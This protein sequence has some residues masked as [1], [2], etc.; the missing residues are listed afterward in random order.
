MKF[1]ICWP[2]WS[3]VTRSD[4]TRAV[5][6][7]ASSLLNSWLHWMTNTS[8]KP[9]TNEP[10]PN[11]T[12]LPLLNDG[13]PART[14]SKH[15]QLPEAQEFRFSLCV[16]LICRLAPTWIRKAPFAVKTTPN[17][18][19]PDGSPSLVDNTDCEMKQSVERKSVSRMEQSGQF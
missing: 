18:E 4:N 13:Q 11:P 19:N 15:C 8:D 1:R 12:L 16:T 3:T 7:P 5:L 14:R 2:I 9:P 6:F 10:N 17:P